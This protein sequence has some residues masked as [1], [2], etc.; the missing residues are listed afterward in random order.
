M[1]SSHSKSYS[2]AYPTSY[3]TPHGNGSYETAG[4][5]SNSVNSAQEMNYE[6]AMQARNNNLA[7][8]I[9]SRIGD[10]ETGGVAVAGGDLATV[11]KE[12]KYSEMVRVLAMRNSLV[13]TDEM[14]CVIVLMLS[15]DD[16]FTT[17]I[18]RTPTVGIVGTDDS[19]VPTSSVNEMVETQM[20]GWSA[21]RE[22]QQYAAVQILQ[23]IMQEIP[24]ANQLR[25]NVYIVRIVSD[26][27]ESV[28]NFVSFGWMNRTLPFHISIEGGGNKA[29]VIQNNSGGSTLVLP[30]SDILHTSMTLAC[31]AEDTLVKGVGWCGSC[32]VSG[33]NIS[34]S[35]FN[36]ILETFQAKIKYDSEEAGIESSGSSA[37]TV[38]KFTC[39][40]VE[41][42][43]GEAV[44]SSNKTCRS[45]G[46]LVRRATS[47]REAQ[48]YTM[49]EGGSYYTTAAI[50]KVASEQCIS[51]K[52][53]WPGSSVPIVPEG[54]YNKP[55]S[56]AA[57]S[58]DYESKNV[59]G[60]DQVFANMEGVQEP[61]TQIN[62]IDTIMSL[63]RLLFKKGFTFD[64]EPLNLASDTQESV[65]AS[66]ESS[67]SSIITPE[68]R[69]AASAIQNSM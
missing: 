26:R 28:T 65:L 38:Y 34:D 60:M 36:Q 15:S 9:E 69:S 2:S 46:I 14:P 51:L 3:N 44:A 37:M 8:Y 32:S 24:V 16:N 11:A 10:T 29:N 30:L 48:Y 62:S 20:V 42:A 25:N 22:D 33:S 59:K 58:L 66:S 17:P 13:P 53:N 7:M 19:A 67:P 18:R 6:K 21:M 40:S 61:C 63:A 5:N 49:V 52:W 27:D 31:F 39:P 45:I 1:G 12:K 43:A 54:I 4:D 64:K 68:I 56:Y 47:D 35:Q 55:S 57:V 50:L 23:E 41:I